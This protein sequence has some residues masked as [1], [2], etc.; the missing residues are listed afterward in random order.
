MAFHSL[1]G[2]CLCTAAHEIDD[3]FTEFLEEKVTNSKDLDERVGLKS[4]LDTIEPIRLSLAYGQF[5][6]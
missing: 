1:G 2:S 6:I 5:C 4:L 3:R